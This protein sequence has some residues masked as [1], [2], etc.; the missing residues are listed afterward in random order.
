MVRRGQV[1][2]KSKHGGRPPT[3]GKSGTVYDRGTGQ[4]PGTLTHGHT[5]S[6][7]TPSNRAL[8]ELMD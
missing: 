1:R 3:T 5:S 6:S 4:S 7:C 8:G 2:K